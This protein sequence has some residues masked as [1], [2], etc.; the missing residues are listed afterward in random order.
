MKE[1][2]RIL[3][4][5]DDQIYRE[6]LA[7]LLDGIAGIRVVA[8]AAN[9]AQAITEL[10]KHL[11]DVALVDI[12]MPVMDGISTAKTIQTS[13]PQTTVV[14]L[15]AFEHEDT[16]QDS[17]ATGVAGFLTKDVSAEDLALFIHQAHDGRQVISG[18]PA[19]M[20]TESY[21]RNQRKQVQY[22][23]FIAKVEAMSKH[24]K[25]V[26]ELMCQAKSNQEIASGLH[27]SVSTVKSYVSDILRETGC[28][29]RSEVTLN[30]I[31]SGIVD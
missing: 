30:A 16:L 27:L 21:L 17:L 10:A 13:Y 18:K 11:V 25:P 2:L 12:D 29:S 22:Q 24:L 6:N 28:N 15:T 1:D 26:L 3:I 23:D 19:E 9:G 8:T 5:D 7:I 14:M 31:K 20:L 4:A